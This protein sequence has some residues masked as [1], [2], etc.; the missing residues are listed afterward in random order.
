M[1]ITVV[2]DIHLHRWP[3]GDP[4]DR[5]ANSVA[6]LEFALSR[7]SDEDVDLVAFTG[8][9]F[10]TSGRVSTSV[11]QAAYA[12]FKRFSGLPFVFVPG[13]HDQTHR[14]QEEH[15]ICFLEQFGPVASFAQP[16]H[17]IGANMPR[18]RMLPYTEDEDQIKSF[19]D[20]SAAGSIVLM[21]QGVK[22]VEMN[23][24]GFVLNEGIDADWIPD[25]ILGLFTGHYHSFRRFAKAG[26]IP[27]SLVQHNFGDVGDPR[28]FL[29]VEG[30]TDPT[31]KQI[32][33]PAYRF[34]D[35][36][37]EESTGRTAE[38][39]AEIGEGNFVRVKN[40]PPGLVAELQ[41]DLVARRAWAADPM[42]VPAVREAHLERTEVDVESSLMSLFDQY[43]S[44]NNVPEA[45][46]T[47][48]REILNSLEA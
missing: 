39:A 45:E 15:A 10:H 7:A 30:E 28:G 6:A 44:V 13:N 23:S 24:K 20:A 29:L 47:V 41:S 22:N 27:G 32:E 43:V 8:D 14:G 36:E 46:A 1:K 12:T 25:E 33:C 38:L 17:I 2:S 21:H 31:I 9:V 11:L 26:T 16:E 42:I 34:F 5:L 37:F 3:Y 19:L 35:V 18:V 48:G 4:D 40:V